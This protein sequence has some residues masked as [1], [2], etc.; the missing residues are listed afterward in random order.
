MEEKH[1]LHDQADVAVGDAQHDVGLTE[2]TER[3]VTT[4]GHG[5]V[6]QKQDWKKGEKSYKKGKKHAGL[7]QV[8]AKSSP[9][10]YFSTDR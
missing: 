5:E 3:P 10:T 4:E 9:A 6:N 8:F 7:S 1:D 2:V